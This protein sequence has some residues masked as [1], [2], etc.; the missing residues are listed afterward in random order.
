MAHHHRYNCVQPTPPFGDR[1]CWVIALW[2]AGGTRRVELAIPT[3][4]IAEVA[5]GVAVDPCA[6]RCE[7]VGPA[8]GI[9]PRSG[10]VRVGAAGCC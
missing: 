6:G 7:Y 10:H 9:V 4:V 3:M 5:G 1:G 8:M 2:E